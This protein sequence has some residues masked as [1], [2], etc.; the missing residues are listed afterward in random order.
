MFFLLYKYWT[1]SCA[2]VSDYWILLKRCLLSSLFEAAP[3]EPGLF[4]YPV[5]EKWSLTLAYQGFMLT[6]LIGNSILLIVAVSRTI[7]EV[8]LSP[9]YFSWVWYQPCFI[10]LCKTRISL[11]VLPKTYDFF[12]FFSTFT[13]THTQRVHL[14]EYVDLNDLSKFILGLIRGLLCCAG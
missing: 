13:Y 1:D 11:I 14:K 9:G 2:W 7:Q 12:F 8:V 6:P 3:L 4:I 10:T 5:F